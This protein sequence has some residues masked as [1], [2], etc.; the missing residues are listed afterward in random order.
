MTKC[1]PLA[2]LAGFTLFIL[3]PSVLLVDCSKSPDSPKS[4]AE[5]SANPTTDLAPLIRDATA[6]N[7]NAQLQLG[8]RYLGGTNV[9]PNYPE[10]VKWLEQAAQSGNA[11]AEFLLG[12][13]YQT[14]QGVKRDY[15]NALLWFE[16]AAAQKHREA[17]YNL[18][19]L[20]G[21]GRG[22]AQDSE[23]AAHYYLQAAELG[24]SYAQFNVAQRYELGRGVSTNFV[25][26][27]KW[28]DLA[29]QGGVEDAIKSKR[30]LETRMTSA[31]VQESR[32]AVA[33]FQKRAPGKN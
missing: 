12:T 7:T 16:K 14:G 20:Y 32:Q 24:D 26:S 9:Q 11:Q 27:W 1:G 23:K 21:S 10:A 28:F 13:L 15:T 3:F 19:S 33:D 25:E 6:G 29:A 17:L 8:I 22:V 4:G 2:V 30:T 18:G 31:Q 5:I